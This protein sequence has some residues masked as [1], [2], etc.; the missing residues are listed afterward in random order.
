M[1]WRGPQTS[2]GSEIIQSTPDIPSSAYNDLPDIT[3]VLKSPDFF[4]VFSSLS[5]PLITIAISDITLFWL[6]EYFLLGLDFREIISH[7]LL[8]L[9]LI[10]T[11][12]S[13]TSIV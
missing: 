2:E 5:L 10:N 3:L 12:A 4:G 7:E 13:A 9:W 6:Q 11:K 8:I 1:E